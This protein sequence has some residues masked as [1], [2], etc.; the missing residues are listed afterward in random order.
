MWN[1]KERFGKG[2]ILEVE[3]RQEQKKIG[4]KF[5][6]ERSILKVISHKEATQQGVL[7]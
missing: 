7:L 4:K 3:M 5:S 1:H 2:D 6:L